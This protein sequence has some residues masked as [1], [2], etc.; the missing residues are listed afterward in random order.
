MYTSSVTPISLPEW[1]L[2]LVRSQ[3]QAEARTW[4]AAG[5]AHFV[6]EDDESKYVQPHIE[7]KSVSQRDLLERRM[8]ALNEISALPTIDYGDCDFGSTPKGGSSFTGTLPMY[9][10]NKIPR[11]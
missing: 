11:T 7:P 9:D 4:T 6:P 3:L 10:I 2:E 8:H 1:E 5:I